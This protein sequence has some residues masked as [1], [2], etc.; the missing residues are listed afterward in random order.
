MR[1]MLSLENEV[2]RLF[3]DLA[4]GT[5]GDT[6][7]SFWAPRVDIEET[8]ENYLVKAELP[9]AKLEEIKITLTDD[10]LVIRGEKRREVEKDDT[11]YH[12]VERV[13]GS[14]ERAFSLPKAVAADKIEAIF[15]DGVLEVRVPKAEEAKARE[16]QI[17]TAK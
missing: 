8:R 11:T 4:G 17:K 5:P 16:I 14:F 13:Y 9:G 6:S 10:Q 12:R 7:P 2:G 15:R 3:T 1:D